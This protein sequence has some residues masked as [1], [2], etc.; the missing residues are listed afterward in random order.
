M[1]AAMDVE[2]FREW[3][4][5]LP[6]QAKSQREQLFAIL[7]P[8]LGQ[9]SVCATIENARPTLPCPHCGAGRHH[10][11]GFDRRLQ[12][13]R[14]CACR[15]IFSAFAGTPCFVYPQHKTIRRCSNGTG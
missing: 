9:E 4:D 15:K 5:R 10:R 1:E 7:G 13:Y 2:G 6:L 12:R 14:C 11:H 8:A 3:L